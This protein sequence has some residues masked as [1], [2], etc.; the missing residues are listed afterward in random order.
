MRIWRYVATKVRDVGTGTDSWEIRE[1]YPED[2]GGFS[3][4]AGP[5]SPAGDDLAELVRDLDNMAADAPLPWLD[6]TGDHPRL[7]N[8]AST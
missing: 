4:T 2:D 7:V 8:D 6:L 5:I 3:Y 1:L